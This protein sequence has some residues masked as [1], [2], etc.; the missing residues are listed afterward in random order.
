VNSFEIS[1][2]AAAAD[3]QT[4]A[5]WMSEASNT[6]TRLYVARQPILDLKGR[7]FGYELLY[8]EDP[9]DRACF[10]DGDTASA[11]V[12]TGALLDLGLNTLTGGRQAFFNLTRGRPNRSS[13]GD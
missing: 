1:E 11:S 12:L 7:V 9:R 10:A 2:C 6:A 3:Y 13:I 8:R 5:S 4:R